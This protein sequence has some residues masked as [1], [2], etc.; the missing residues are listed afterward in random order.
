LQ[1]FWKEAVIEQGYVPKGCTLG[2]GIVWKLINVAIDPCAGC[3]E[4]RQICRGRPREG[5]TYIPK[6]QEQ[7]EESETVRR[8]KATKAKDRLKKLERG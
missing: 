3:D 4:N 5:D 7:P 2:G 6:K 8:L 1:D